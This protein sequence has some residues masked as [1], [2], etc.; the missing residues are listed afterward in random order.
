VRA[1]IRRLGR[2]GD[3]EGGVC[4][5]RHVQSLVENPGGEIS[6]ALLLIVRLRSWL[7]IEH[8]LTAFA[9]GYS[10]HRVSIAARLI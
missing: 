8:S 10:P 6:F 5:A 1:N 3:G 2:R 4:G 9:R 7:W